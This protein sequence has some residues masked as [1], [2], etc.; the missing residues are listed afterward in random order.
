MVLGSSFVNRHEVG[1]RIY[2]VIDTLKTRK[3]TVRR[4]ENYSSLKIIP[5]TPKCLPTSLWKTGVP[6]EII[7][8]EDGEKAIEHLASVSRTV[9]SPCCDIVLLD[10]N[11]PRVMSRSRDIDEIDLLSSGRELMHL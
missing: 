5:P 11:L 9:A 7:R 3:L 4:K 10:L 8:I 2:D 1:R 6:V